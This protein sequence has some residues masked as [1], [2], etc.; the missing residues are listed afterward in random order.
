MRGLPGATSG[1]KEAVVIDLQEVRK[2]AWH[3]AR[4]CYEYEK[5]GA[6]SQP[7]L[8]GPTANMLRDLADEV[9]Q[10]QYGHSVFDHPLAKENRR[11]EHIIKMLN[12]EPLGDFIYNVRDREGQGW[13]GPRMKNWG[14]ACMKVKE[15]AGPWTGK[16]LDNDEPPE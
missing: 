14:Q 7:A 13:D 2:A 16:L 11:L 5:M 8:Y 15:I 9:E 6:S 1:E 10:L 4:I 3:F 12:V